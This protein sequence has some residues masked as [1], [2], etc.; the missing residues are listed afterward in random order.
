MLMKSIIMTVQYL[1]VLLLAL[2]LVGCGARYDTHIHTLTSDIVSAQETAQ[3]YNLTSQWWIGYNST[4]LD[5]TVELALQRNVNLARTAIAVNRALYQA[6][7]LE[8][9]LIPAFSADVSAQTT[10]TFNRNN[11]SSAWQQTWAGGASVNYELDLWRRLHDTAD[12][13][14]WEYQATIED[15]ASTRL[16][17]INSVVSSWFY[18]AYTGQAINIM[19]NVVQRYERLAELMQDK[20]NAGQ[21]A[22][23]EKLQAEQSLL[24]ARND[25]SSLHTQKAEAAQTMRDLLNLR[26]GEDME[27]EWSDLLDI[28]LVPVDLNVP[29]AALSAR[30]DIR[31]A[32]ARLQKS[33][34]TLEADKSAWY[35][36]ISVG[37][38][39]NVSADR[40]YKY[41]D[42]PVLTGLVSLTLPFLN[43][44]T[45][46]WNIKTSE[47]DFETAKLDLVE[48]VTTALNE[49]DAACAAYIEARLTLEQTIAKHERNMKI[50]EYYRNRYESGAA[51]FKDY[52][53]AQNSADDSA[54]SVLSAKYTLLGKESTIYM[55]MG[56]RYV[57][58]Q[59]QKQDTPPPP[60]TPSNPDL[61][62]S[63]Q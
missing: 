61:A 14:Q 49:V 32:E 50:A 4:G 57:P 56:G 29:I 34:K 48:T 33:F 46:Y 39:L 53:E 10:R 55:A 5:H 1:S 25:I 3:R 43:W 27:Q 9:D 62:L 41:F 42:V 54:L 28:P 22:V 58:T 36:S 63:L 16:A 18:L 24:A 45:L 37:S 47:A 35:P 44:N 60:I 51:E 6:R 52:L 59:R 40:A 2:V 21:I 17:L 38:T 31:A 23:L 7:L 8:T 13:G 26:P 12:A 19:D 30:P 11:P 15:L 20:Y